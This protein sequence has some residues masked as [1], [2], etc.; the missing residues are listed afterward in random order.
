VGIPNR[1][2]W[3]NSLTVCEWLSPCSS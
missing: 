2:S 3:L 1:G